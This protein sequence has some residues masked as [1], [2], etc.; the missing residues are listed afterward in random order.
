MPI[1][2][3]NFDLKIV[4]NV[5]FMEVWKPTVECIIV[6][7]NS[8]TV[9]I[10]S[11]LHGLIEEFEFSTFKRTE[12]FE[13]MTFLPWSVTVAGLDFWNSGRMIHFSR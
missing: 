10:L 13:F 3:D 7:R 4:K 12:S 9:A 8:V 6:Q 5:L 11:D 1:L 2:C